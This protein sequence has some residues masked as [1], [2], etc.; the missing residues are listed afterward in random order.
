VIT[1]KNKVIDY[2]YDALGRRTA[3]IVRE[4]K[5]HL[6]IDSDQAVTNNANKEERTIK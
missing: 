5:R 6:F 4:Q 3:K 2:E 1:P